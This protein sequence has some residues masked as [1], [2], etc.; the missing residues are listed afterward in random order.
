MR[1][2]GYGE[3]GFSFFHTNVPLGTG[4]MR[5]ARRCRGNGGLPAGTLAKKVE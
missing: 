1:R 5:G 4:G 3:W 2:R